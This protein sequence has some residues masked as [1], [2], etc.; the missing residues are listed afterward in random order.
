[1][2]KKALSLIVIVRL[3]SSWAITQP[4]R[5][6]N[7]GA[8]VKKAIKS[9]YLTPDRHSYKKINHAKI[10]GLLNRTFQRNGSVSK[11]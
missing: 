5:P 9:V 4:D 6:F 3:P 11:I 1:M 8:L 2:F 7:Q 10:I